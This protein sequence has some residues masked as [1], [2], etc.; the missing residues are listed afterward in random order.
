MPGYTEAMD[1][2][3]ALVPTVSDVE[4][5]RAILADGSKSFNAASKL[6]PK[7]I[8][9]PAAVFYAFCRVADDAVDESADPAAAVTGLRARLDEVFAGRPRADPVDRALSSVVR[10]Y[11]LPRVLFDALIEGFEWDADGRTYEELN[12]VL[13]YSARVASA[14]GVVMTLL[15]GVRDPRAIA[16]ACEMG[17]AMQLTNIARD[18]GEDAG[19]G[20]L[21]LPRRWLLEEG[22]D[23]AAFVRAPRFDPAVARVTAR[24]L[25]EAARLYRRGD[26]GVPLLPSDCR[27]SIRAARAIYSDLGRVIAHA[28]HDSVNRRAYVTTA[29]K[30]WLVLCAYL[31]RRSAEDPA[32]APLPEF[33][34]LVEAT[35][36]DSIE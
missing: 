2:S 8:R 12:D 4:A 1:A 15:M 3:T 25:D 6:L 32:A 35:N 10:R 26:A 17:G 29:R 30:I 11:R 18:V 24:L 9:D 5:C 21:Y 14:V 20:R 19:R 27:P 7:R 33:A 36:A 16:R 34:F 28:G 22:I 13:D 31:P 23:P